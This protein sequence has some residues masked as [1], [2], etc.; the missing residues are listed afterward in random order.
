MTKTW[1]AEPLASYR[2]SENALFASGIE[3][4]WRK[5]ACGSVHE[6]PAPEADANQ[7]CSTEARYIS[8]ISIGLS[9]SRSILGDEGR[10]KIT[11]IKAVGRGAF[12]ACYD[13]VVTKS[14][15]VVRVL[16]A[17]LMITVAAAILTYVH[18]WA[19]AKQTPSLHS[20]ST[21]ATANFSGFPRFGPAP[22]TVTFTGV[23]HGSYQGDVSIDFGDGS[24][25]GEYGCSGGCSTFSLPNLTNHVYQNSGTY[26]ATLTYDPRN[27]R[28]TASIGSVK[29]TVTQ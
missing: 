17:L 25:P 12:Y 18:E 6:S 10:V 22:L 14:L 16:I 26:I 19:P 23:A 5:R 9:N 7:S 3:A 1:R 13:S 11:S 24:K 29:I 27:L 15:T 20:L 4:G 2:G 8:R 28:K 21:T